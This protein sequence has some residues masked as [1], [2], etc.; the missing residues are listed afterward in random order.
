[1]RR[2]HPS[3][4]RYSTRSVAGPLAVAVTVLTVAA[5]V[6]AIRIAVDGFGPAALGLARLAVAAVVLGAAAIVMRPPVPPRHLWPR[7]LAV[8]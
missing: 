8:G 3:A 1:L 4:S 2:S 5:A 7:V 6:P